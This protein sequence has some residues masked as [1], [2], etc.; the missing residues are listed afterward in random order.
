MICIRNFIEYQKLSLPKAGQTIL[1][2][3]ELYAM[4]GHV[5]DRT[6]KAEKGEL[7]A[8][9]NDI[10]IEVKEGEALSIIGKNILD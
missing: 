3:D 4:V 6:Q 5:N 7:V 8:A 10:N 9:L 2:Q 1:G